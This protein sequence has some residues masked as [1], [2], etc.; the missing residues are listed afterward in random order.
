MRPPFTYSATVLSLYDGDTVH[1]SVRVARWRRKD[2]DLG[3]FHLY[4]EGGWLATHIRGRLLG[5]NAPELATV[6]GK[7]ALAYLQT[8]VSPGDV[9]TVRSAP[10]KPIG[11]DKY[12]DRWDLVLIRADGLNV[13]DAMVAAGHATPYP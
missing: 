8:L 3:G 10:G 1:L 9:L 4:A 6:D 2:A 5:I 7:A 13:N 12:G 11:P